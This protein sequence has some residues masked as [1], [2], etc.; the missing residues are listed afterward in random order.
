MARRMWIVGRPLLAAAAAAAALLVAACSSLQNDATLLPDVDIGA[1]IVHG[2][3][4]GGAHP[5]VGLLITPAPSGGFYI[6]SGTLMSPTVF[7]TAAHC[8]AGFDASTPSYVTF[9]ED[10]PYGLWGDFVAAAERYPHPDW[11]NYAAFPDTFDIGVVILSE[12]VTTQGYG[13]LPPAGFF[14]QATRA[15][16]RLRFT[17][18]GYGLQDAAPPT[19]MRPMEPWDLARYQAMQSFITVNSANTGTHTVMLTNNPGFGNGSGGTCSGDSGGPILLAD[20]NVV[21]AVNSF[22]IAP[23]CVGNDY[24]FRTD[25]EVARAF[26]QDFLTLP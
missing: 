10:G 3:P 17:P 4:D 15:L 19:S 11:A 16:K 20:T 18:V 25:T 2:Q 26:L 14:D 21:T 1:S 6:C 5:Y 12:G 13:A 23:Y 8:I 24:A 9:K 7:L 22:G